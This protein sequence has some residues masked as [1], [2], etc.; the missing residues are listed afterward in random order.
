MPVCCES[1]Q[2]NQLVA[3]RVYSQQVHSTCDQ[4]S[5]GFVYKAAMIGREMRVLA[6]QM[7]HICSM[8]PCVVQ[9]CCG[10]LRVWPSS[11]VRKVSALSAL[12]LL[13]WLLVWQMCALC[14]AGTFLS[15]MAA[16][17]VHHCSGCAAMLPGGSLFRHHP[18]G[19][20]VHLLAIVCVMCG[21]VH[22]M[23]KTRALESWP[24]AVCRTQMPHMSLHT[25][26]SN[27]VS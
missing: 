18:S 15:S 8:V 23:D 20:V 13:Y 7:L 27:A 9:R 2:C 10:D 21:L 5:S 17:M 3:R 26:W 6:Q 22:L 14:V 25:R 19:R 11:C 24:T 1:L 16:F 4:Q 12:L